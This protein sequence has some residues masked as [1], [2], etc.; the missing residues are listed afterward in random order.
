VRDFVEFVLARY[1][2]QK[3]PQ[4][5]TTVDHIM[6]LSKRNPLVPIP[7]RA[8]LIT[9]LRMFDRGLHRVLVTDSLDNKEDAVMLCQSDIISWIAAHKTDLGESGNKTMEELGMVKKPYTISKTW[10]SVNAFELLRERHIHGMAVVENDSN[11]IWGNVSVTDLKFAYENNMK[12]DLPLE[13]F[14][15]SHKP[16]TCSPQAKLGDV[17]S[18]LASHNVHRIHIVDST[19]VPVGVV[20]FTDI[21]DIM[22]VLSQEHEGMVD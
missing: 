10:A 21:M 8:N 5:E 3:S 13:K 22:L 15:N 9:V 1:R 20:S 7:K 12:L 17:I 2:Q 16:L 14:L 19:S 4:Q 18:S 6:N 11:K